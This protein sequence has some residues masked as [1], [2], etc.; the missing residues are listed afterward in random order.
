VA[1]LRNVTFREP[2]ENEPWTIHLRARTHRDSRIRPGTPEDLH[3]AFGSGLI[4]GVIRPEPELTES[5]EPSDEE[6]GRP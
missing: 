3:K 2:D 1:K 4:G 5:S 6:L